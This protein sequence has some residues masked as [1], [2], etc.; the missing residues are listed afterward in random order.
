MLLILQGYFFGLILLQSFFPQVW[1]F[2]VFRFHFFLLF[3]HKIGR[4]LWIRQRFLK[5]IQL[6]FS[7]ILLELATTFWYVNALWMFETFFKI[8]YI[9]YALL[10]S[11]NEMLV[12]LL[13]N[14]SGF[15][16]HDTIP[17]SIALALIACVNLQRPLV[18]QIHEVIAEN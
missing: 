3:V 14:I 4:R 10:R 8:L 1:I 13:L 17:V 9:I 16:V 7:D 18:F 12:T 11:I 15:Q 5:A 2:I 6:V